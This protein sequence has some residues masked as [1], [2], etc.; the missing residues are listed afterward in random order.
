MASKKEKERERELPAIQQ[1]QQHS[2]FFFHYFNHILHNFIL[3]AKQLTD[4]VI[5]GII[6]ALTS[7]KWVL[8][9]RHFEKRRLCKAKNSAKNFELWANSAVELDGLLYFDSLF[10]FFLFVFFFFFFFF[11]FS[12][13]MI[14]ILIL[15]S[16]FYPLTIP[17]CIK[18]NLFF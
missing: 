2:F 11:F 12:D 18:D 8:Y 17:K 7:L 5:R 15:I 4:I 13:F 9:Q 3:I 16:L 6:I 14:L 10:L 1:H